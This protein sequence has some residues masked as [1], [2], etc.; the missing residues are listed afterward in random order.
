MQS[1]ECVL[2]QHPSAARQRAEHTARFALAVAGLHTA[3]VGAPSCAGKQP[4]RLPVLQRKQSACRLLMASELPW[5]HRCA[6]GFAYEMMW[7]TSRARWCSWAPQ[8]SQRPRAAVA[9]AV[10]KHLLAALLSEGIEALAAQLLQRVALGVAR[11]VAADQAV[12]AI[13]IGGDAVEGERS[14]PCASQDPAGHVVRGG[15]A[16]GNSGG[17]RQGVALVEEKPCRDAMPC[18]SPQPGR[19]P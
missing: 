19:W 16:Q 18:L 13:A 10:G 6:E 4:S 9:A 8:Y 1:F 15:G 17:V 12:V 3:E 2:Q 5:F 7:S 14:P 11:L